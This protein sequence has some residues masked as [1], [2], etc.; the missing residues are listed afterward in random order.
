M[1]PAWPAFENENIDR[2]CNVECTKL[3][4]RVTR[5]LLL[6]TKKICLN[7]SK[8]CFLNEAK[9]KGSVCHERPRTIFKL[10]PVICAEA[11]FRR[12]ARE[13]FYAAGRTLQQTSLLKCIRN[14]RIG[15][16]PRCNLSC[17]A[18]ATL[19]VLIHV[20]SIHRRI[21]YRYL[22]R[23]QRSYL[24]GKKSSVIFR[25]RFLETRERAMVNWPTL[26]NSRLSFRCYRFPLLYIV[27]NVHFC[28]LFALLHI[29]FD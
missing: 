24:R 17:F 3:D 21:L 23:Q 29:S 20:I 12:A 9:L 27:F 13:S 28:W 16:Y 19:N 7:R 11:A 2:G 14:T 15:V 6:A 10:I 25:S 1:K 18:S 5:Y 22:M 8:V 4:T 26:M